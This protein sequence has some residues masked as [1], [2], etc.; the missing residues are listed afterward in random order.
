MKKGLSHGVSNERVYKYCLAYLD[1]SSS[2][3]TTFYI[4]GFLIAIHRGF[5]GRNLS[6][7]SIS[8]KVKCQN[9]L[10]LPPRE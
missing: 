8:K 10:H 5:I 2:L 9:P 4:L 3:L 6:G 1:Y 7:T